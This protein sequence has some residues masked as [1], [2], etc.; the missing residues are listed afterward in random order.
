MIA[1]SDSLYVQVNPD[2]LPEFASLASF[3]FSTPE[4]R[5]R[6]I[7]D[8]LDSI[9]SNGYL[10]YEQ[11]NTRNVMFDARHE[12][13]SVLF[14]YRICKNAREA[15]VVLERVKQALSRAEKSNG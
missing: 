14:K 11:K 3:A 6:K 7:Q 12:K 2:G 13:S 5:L 8:I 1:N 9:A 10:C 4:D 15:E